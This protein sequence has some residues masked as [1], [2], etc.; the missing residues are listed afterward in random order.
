MNMPRVHVVSTQRA[1]PAWAKLPP[2]ALALNLSSNPF[3]V[4]PDETHYFFTPELEAIYEELS[5]F[6]EMRKGFLLLTGDVGLGKT[7]L[8]RRLLSSLDNARYNTALILTS[9]LDQTELLEV[10]GRDFGLTLPPGA[11]R[12]D[13]L[14]A[15]NEFLL[16][17]SAAGKVNVLFIDDAQA[18]NADA[19]DVV[20]QLSNL[21]TAQS[22]LIQVVLCGQPEL[23]DT[24]NQYSLR[25]VKSRI[26]LHRQLQPLD[27]AQALAYIQHRLTK[28]G[29]SDGV[30]ITADGLH[31][32]HECT[33]GFP[34]RIHHLMD[35]CLYAAAVSSGPIDRALVARAWEDLGWQA[36]ATPAPVASA[37]AQAQPIQ[38]PRPWRLRHTGLAW[39]LAAL[40][41]ATVGGVFAKWGPQNPIEIS[42][43]GPISIAAPAPVTVPAM[44]AIPTDWT[45]SSASFAGLEGLEW[46][47]AATVP[48]LV[49]LLQKSLQP[50]PWQTVV[51][52][53]N[54]TTPCRARPLMALQDAQG[55]TW[56]LSFIESGWPMT[57][58]EL[59]HTS[60][61][62]LN[63]QQ[64]LATQ[65]WLARTE[66]DGI[67]GL[68]T[69]SALARFQIT[70]GIQSTGQFN[71]ATAYRLSCNLA[72]SSQ[73]LS[74]G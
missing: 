30:E 20:R 2:Y 44:I 7:T 74:K 58:V 39:L 35:R 62:M 9:F 37:L 31:M 13:H 65:G 46:P 40:C 47:G 8:L 6:I 25:Q 68:R 38:K 61:T 14:A 17:E 52:L 71:P 69:A 54:W 12:I 56:H 67:M 19:L 51:E 15:L 72:F 5:H 16:T 70:Q 33:G 73:P 49:E 53:G 18:L 27:P 63:L 34:R 1:K 3:P 11:R 50:H 59:G 42:V 10:L 43:A 4:T 22:K 45:T 64:F 48:E 55:A 29:S 26:A 32:L 28:A 66:V 24:L 36:S 21:E 41:V 23:V 60:K 57:Q